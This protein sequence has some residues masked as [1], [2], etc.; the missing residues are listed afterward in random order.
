MIFL[1]NGSIY[2]LSSKNWF[3]KN[4]QKISRK[5]EPFWHFNCLIYRNA[6]KL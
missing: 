6:K 3:F 4:F 2:D 5:N 1:D